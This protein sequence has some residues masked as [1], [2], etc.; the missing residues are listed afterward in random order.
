MARV[1]ADKYI[2]HQTDSVVKDKSASTQSGFDPL[3]LLTRCH[4]NFIE[5]VP[6]CFTLAGIAELNGGNRTYLN[7]A[8]AA[9]LVFRVC[10][11]EIGLKRPKARGIGRPIGYFGTSFWQVFMSMY[12]A[13]LAK[14]Y[15][16]Y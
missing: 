10:H 2:G 4:A 12:C 15:Y 1:R 7:Y 3:L 11:V 6:L 14:G 8:M 16:G 9:L 13:Y 5:N